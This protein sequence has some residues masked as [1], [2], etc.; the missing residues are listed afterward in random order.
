MEDD[1]EL[2]ILMLGLKV[3]APTHSFCGVLCKFIFMTGVCGYEGTSAGKN[4]LVLFLIRCQI[5][6]GWMEERGESECVL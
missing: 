1:L 6:V 5:V 3:C 4:W 2:F